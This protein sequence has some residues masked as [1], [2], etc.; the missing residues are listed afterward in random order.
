MLTSL[1]NKYARLSKN[2][3]PFLQEEALFPAEIHAISAI[4]ERREVNVTELANHVGTTK[5]AASQLVK[6]LTEKGFITKHQDPQKRSRTILRPTPKG[7]KAHIS[8]ME[9]H[10]EHD[11]QF[12]DYLATLSPKEFSLFRDICSQMNLWMDSYFT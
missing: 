12:L 8:H 5:G 7:L 3:I 10:M 4:A 1:L 2:P 6:K 11:K 9:F